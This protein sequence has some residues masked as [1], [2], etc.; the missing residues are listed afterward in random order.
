MVDKEVETAC[1]ELKKA[2]K[3]KGD[4]LVNFIL[5]K[6]QNQ[7]QEIREAFKACWG[8]D[9]LKEI[10]KSLSGHFKEA[11]SAL[12]LRP[13]EFDAECLYKAMKGLGTDEETLIEIIC[14]RGNESLKDVK[15]EF[16]KKYPKYNLE[17]W[18]S[19]ETSG[20]FRKLLVSLLQCR[21]NEN[22]QPDEEE[23]RKLAQ[24]LYDA[25]EKKLGTDEPV[26]NKIFAIASPAELFCIS[27]KYEEI[28]KN[29]LKVAIDK[30]YSRD[31]KKALITILDAVINPTEYFARKVNKAVKGLGTN[32]PMLIRVL[33]SREGVDMS[34]MRNCYTNIFKKDMIED[35]KGDTSGDYRKL[36]VGLASGY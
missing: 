14:T 2:L 19:S 3:T 30:E 34:E 16:N 23:C 11:V 29:S 17:S 25:G 5:D 28:S 36:L 32:D 20:S 21:R 1:E 12:F 24:E 31:I 15:E 27:G 7:R 13:A 18:V 33:V 9:L 22:A 10:D 26:F 4:T 35:I 6:S 8:V